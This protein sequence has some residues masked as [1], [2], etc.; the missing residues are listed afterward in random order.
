VIDGR[1]EGNWWTRGAVTG[2]SRLRVDRLPPERSTSPPLEANF[3]H[4][5]AMG[6]VTV[7]VHA[8]DRNRWRVAVEIHACGRGLVRPF[9]AIS[10]PWLAGAVRRQLRASMAGLSHWVKT[11][12]DEWRLRASSATQRGIAQQWLDDF[13][14]S[15]PAS[16]PGTPKA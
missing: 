1:L 15:L 3:R 11:F 6:T 4:R 10:A 14:N 9:A 2:E 16:V 12:N 8:S 5:R 7:R 13:V